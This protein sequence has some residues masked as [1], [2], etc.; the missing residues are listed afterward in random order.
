MTS[1][2]IRVTRLR[3]ISKGWR[4]A[5]R[6]TVAALT[7]DAATTLFHLHQGQWAVITCLVVVQGTFANTLDASLSRI[8]GTA[9][10]ALAGTAGVAVAFASRPA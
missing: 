8:Y 1:R 3:S 10:G 9:A 5:I 6:M 4:Q 7:A 2:M